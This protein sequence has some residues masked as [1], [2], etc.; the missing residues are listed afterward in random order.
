MREATLK[1]E[2]G[3]GTLRA[4][5]GQIAVASASAELRTDGHDLHLQSLRLAQR[6]AAGAHLAPPTLT[7]SADARRTPAGWHATFSA[8]LDHASFAD[9]AAYW[10][11]G[12]GGGARPW[13][14]QNITAGTATDGHATGAVD[15]AADLS[16]LAV[17][18]LEGGVSASDMTVY[19]LRPV[20]PLEHAAALLTI[21]GPD[22]LH[23]DMPR[24]AQGALAASAGRIAITG[25][26]R[27]HQIGDIAVS[28]DG[29]LKP[30]LDLLNNPRLRLLSRRPIPLTDPAGTASVKLRMTLPLED[31]VTFDQMGV[32][33]TA[34]LTKVHLGKIAAGRDL[35]DGTLD[36]AGECRQP[37]NDRHG[38]GRRRAD[39]SRC[40]HGFPRRAA[41]PG[42]GA[43]YRAWPRHGGPA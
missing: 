42:A 9:L 3:A 37:E 27:A 12:T 43:L 1:A 17:T 34:K 35:D 41:E 28:V 38:A 14:T 11:L 31:S 40:R 33:A 7:A 20:P 29:G 4:G 25:L 18:A 32:S 13:V 26:S 6:P 16:S 2:V 22:A 15:V 39:R 23:I 10:P 24:A 36:L 19:W 30:L 21:D 5:R 8:G